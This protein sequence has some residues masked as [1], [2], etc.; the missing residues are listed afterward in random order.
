[1]TDEKIEAL[2]AVI[3]GLYPKRAIGDLTEKKFQ[4]ELT[5]RT[6]DLYRALIRQKTKENELFICEHHVLQS[7]FKMT[8]S[9]LK[10]PEQENISLFATDRSLFHLKSTLMPGR[11]PTADKEDNFYMKE[12]PFQKIK[13]VRV[14]RQIR[15]EEIGMGAAIAGLAALFYSSLSITGPFLVGLGVLGMLHGLLLPTRWVQVETLDPASESVL[16]Y[17]LR[18]KSARR[19]VKFL[20]D[21]MRRK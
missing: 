13:S 7:H 15:I 18:K 10:E 16:I 14:K 6:L 12:L 20:R 8:H 3:R 17:A 19:M 4:H 5:D 2:R 21:K 1:M 11:P 9:V